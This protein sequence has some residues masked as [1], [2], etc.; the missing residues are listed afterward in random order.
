LKAGVFILPFTPT[1]HM[2]HYLALSLLSSLLLTSCSVD[3]NDAN[4]KKIGELEKQV[5]EMKK[6]K[7]LELQ[8]FEFEKQK[9]EE[10]KQAKETKAKNEQ[11]EKYEAQC[12]KNKDEATKTFVTIANT[13][14]SHP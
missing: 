2:K 1:T 11:L 10:E 9:Y 12:Q 8:K 13:N 5:T 7:N 4:V 6:D 14:C 3:W